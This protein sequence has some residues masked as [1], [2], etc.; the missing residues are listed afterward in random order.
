MP[1]ARYSAKSSEE[2]K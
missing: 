1:N 2:I